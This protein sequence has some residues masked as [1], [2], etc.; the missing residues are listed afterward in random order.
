MPLSTGSAR[1]LPQKWDGRRRA[2]LVQAN[3]E[4]ELR[5]QRYE[6]EAQH[7]IELLK[8]RLDAFIE[9]FKAAVKAEPT[10]REHTRAVN[11]TFAATVAKVTLHFEVFPDRDVNQVRLECTQDIVP[12]VVRY[13]K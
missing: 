3:R 8:P 2:E 1:K 5:L 11:L 7:L 4:R 12:A 10:V 13:D 9:L 6:S